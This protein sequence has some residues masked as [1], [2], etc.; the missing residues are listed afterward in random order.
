MSSDLC[1]DEHLKSMLEAEK[2]L[3]AMAKV[4]AD[5]V[6][7]AS[8]IVVCGSGPQAAKMRGFLDRLSSAYASQGRNYT[9]CLGVYPLA[10]ETRWVEWVC[11]CRPTMPGKRFWGHFTPGSTHPELK[12]LTFA[13]MG[14]D[15]EMTVKVGRGVPP[16]EL[17]DA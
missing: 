16:E 3:W 6:G 11:V 1:V 4:V 5:Q 13:N 7:L 12:V 9:T 15:E 14:A 10:I 2:T 8:A 17:R